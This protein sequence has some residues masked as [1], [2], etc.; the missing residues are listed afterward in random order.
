WR[1]FSPRAVL[2]LC[3]GIG[4]L[5]WTIPG[6]SFERFGEMWSAVTWWVWLALLIS[7]YRWLSRY[8]VRRL[9]DPEVL[10]PQAA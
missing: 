6:G 2:H 1:R 5:V 3:G 10:A 8:L 4:F 9:F 7:G